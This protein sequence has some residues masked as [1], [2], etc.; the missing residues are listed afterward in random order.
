MAIGANWVHLRVCMTC[1]RVGCCDSSPNQH[2]SKHAAAVGHP[3]VQ[4][5]EPGEDWWWCYNDQVA[6][7]VEGAP[8][9]THP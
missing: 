3:I 5:F 6:F 9:F 2:A 4:S 7:T 8:S 1:G